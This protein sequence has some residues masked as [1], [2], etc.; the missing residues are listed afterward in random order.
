MGGCQQGIFLLSRDAQ[1]DTQICA[2]TKGMSGFCPFI[3]TEAPGKTIFNSTYPSPALICCTEMLFFLK[4]SL[5][6]VIAKKQLN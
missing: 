3:K 4:A 2:A 5:L 6:K 1:K